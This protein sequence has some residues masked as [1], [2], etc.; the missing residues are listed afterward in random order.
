M[1]HYYKSKSNSDNDTSRNIT[2]LIEERVRKEGG[3]VTHYGNDSNFG[4]NDNGH[5][6]INV[7][8]NSDDSSAS[9]ELQHLINFKRG[10]YPKD[11]YNE[12]NK[13]FKNQNEFFKSIRNK[14]DILDYI[15]TM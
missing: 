14:N 13:K 11:K 2:P 4:W 7:S 6:G 8:P 5:Y 3:T 12:S 1:N 15:S 10:E 9:H